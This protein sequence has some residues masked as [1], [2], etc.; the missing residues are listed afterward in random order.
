MIPFSLWFV[1][2]L[3]GYAS[4]MQP[5]HCFAY[6]LVNPKPTFFFPECMEPWSLELI[7]LIDNI[8]FRL[9]CGMITIYWKYILWCNIGMKIQT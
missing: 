9:C 2:N 5:V 4:E 8:M 3:G 7:N 6:H 1:D